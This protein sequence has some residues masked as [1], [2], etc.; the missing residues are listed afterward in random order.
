MRRLLLLLGAVL[1]LAAAAPV[2]AATTAVRITGTGFA[3]RTVYVSAEDTMTWTNRGTANHQVVSDD[4]TF[5]SPVLAPG[6]TFQH[7]FLVP[8]TANYHDGLNASNKGSVVVA[9]APAPDTITLFASHTTVIDGAAVKL[10]G[11]VSTHKAGETVAIVVTPVGSASR[12]ITVTTGTDGAF[13]AIVAPGLGASY[14]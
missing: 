9:A 8:G 2:S 6:Q 12:T 5:S 13:S 4:G 3:P 7:T 11:T 1:T 14:R 10:S